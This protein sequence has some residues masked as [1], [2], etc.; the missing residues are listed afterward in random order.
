MGRGRWIFGW[1]E[2]PL[3]GLIAKTPSLLRIDRFLMSLDWEKY[4]PY[5]I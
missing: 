3:V 2:V 4:F 1:R 5:L